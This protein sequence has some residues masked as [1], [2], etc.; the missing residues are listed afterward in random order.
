MSILAFVVVLV[1]ALAAGT[2]VARGAGQTFGSGDAAEARHGGQVAECNS[3]G[4]AQA[5]RHEAS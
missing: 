3:G 2:A 5:P 1:A 4:V